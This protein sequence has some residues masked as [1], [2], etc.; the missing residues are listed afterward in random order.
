MQTLEPHHFAAA[1]HMAGWGGWGGTASRLPGTLE[2]AAGPRLA[3][4]T[5]GQVPHPP[6]A[7]ARRMPGARASGHPAR[8]RWPQRRGLGRCAA[9]PAASRLR[10][11]ERAFW[12]G[13]GCAG[14]PACPDMLQVLASTTRAVGLRICHTGVWQA[15]GQEVGF[16]GGGGGEAH[17]A[18]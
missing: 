11:W 9:G 6:L 15:E 2:S 14:D 8:P 18:A 3:L 12:E 1:W 7:G 5:V 4:G 13:G 10:L 17:E 16:E